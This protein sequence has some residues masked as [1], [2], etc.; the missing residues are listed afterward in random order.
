M[1]RGAYFLKQS[2]AEQETPMLRTA[3]HDA[4]VVTVEFD[5]GTRPASTPSGCATTR[6]TPRPARRATAN[7]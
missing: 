6:W 4:S 2:R 7:V 3:T 1:P 5:T